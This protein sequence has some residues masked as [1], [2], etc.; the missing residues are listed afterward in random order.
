MIKLFT[1][2]FR[3]KL[4]DANESLAKLQLLH[5]EAIEE[6][7]NFLDEVL[8]LKESV[9][10][11]QAKVKSLEEGAEDLNKTL[12]LSC[13]IVEE[14]ENFMAQAAQRGVKNR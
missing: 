2:F 8:T 7:F 12:D 1:S 10:S 5:A 9:Q 3:K 14:P 11:L 4:D 13:Y 6:S